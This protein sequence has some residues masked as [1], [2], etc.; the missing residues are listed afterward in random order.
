MNS[1]KN[2]IDG[3]FT[4]YKFKTG[5]NDLFRR[6]EKRKRK[7]KIF[8]TSFL[9]VFVFFILFS[10]FEGTIIGLNA[11]N[12][13]GFKASALTVKICNEGFNTDKEFVKNSF[14]VKKRAKKVKYDKNGVECINGEKAKTTAYRD[15]IV[16]S[17]IML[18]IS[19]HNIKTIRLTCGENGYLYNRRYDNLNGKKTAY[20]DNDKVN[21]IPNCKKLLS[22]LS[23]DASK[24]P[25][26]LKNDRIITKDL[27]KLL[28]TDKDYNKFFGDKVKIT[29]FHKDK[30]VAN[31]NVIISLDKNGKY[32]VTIKE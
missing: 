19:G 14:G 29:A 25:S 26:T 4:D 9:A 31:V 30:S 27:K 12:D 24:V 32:Y 8:L 20:K 28:K 18:K 11:K 13:L 23:A 10:G 16:P 6:Y 22:S 15:V 1:L 2:E 5:C 17:P 3:C 21:W 7:I